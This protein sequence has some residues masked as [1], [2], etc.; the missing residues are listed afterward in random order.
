MQKDE[1]ENKS[2]TLADANG[3]LTAVLRGILIWLTGV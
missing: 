3:D 1:H 2:T